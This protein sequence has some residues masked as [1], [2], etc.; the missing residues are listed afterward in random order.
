MK[1]ATINFPEPLIAGSTLESFYVDF[2]VAD[3]TPMDITSARA[4]LYE[5]KGTI[6]HI[7]ENTVQNGRVTFKDV[8][9]ATTN[10]WPA[11]ELTYRIE[12]TLPSG[13]TINPIKGI[14][15]VEEGLPE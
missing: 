2:K 14:L 5:P 3:G 6:I 10:L 9:A 1:P 11:R 8:A 13:V 7:W 4:V 15:K 12:L